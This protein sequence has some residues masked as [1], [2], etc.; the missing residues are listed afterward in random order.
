MLRRTIAVIPVFLSSRATQPEI[1]FR[2]AA[3]KVIAA[4]SKNNMT[5]NSGANA[6][7]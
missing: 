6:W 7:V 5:N 3:G 2:Y 4:S 1:L